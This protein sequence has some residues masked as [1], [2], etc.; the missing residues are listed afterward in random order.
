MLSPQESAPHPPLPHSVG[1][2]ILQNWYHYR[3]LSDWQWA[4]CGYTGASDPNQGWGLSS[5]ASLALWPST[6]ELTTALILRECCA[7]YT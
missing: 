2:L 3:V 5:Y 7:S 6:V 1:D 4:T